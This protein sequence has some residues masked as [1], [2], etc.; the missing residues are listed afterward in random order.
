[1]TSTPRK[2]LA[3]LAETD[4]EFAEVRAFIGKV[5]YEGKKDLIACLGKINLLDS[6][7]CGIAESLLYKRTEFRH[8]AEVRLIYAG[9][10]GECTSDLYQIPVRPNELFDKFLFDPRMDTMA[11][12]TGRETFRKLGFKNAIERSGLYRAPEGLVFKL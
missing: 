10:D 3:A 1:M 4:P 11:F 6:S 12:K 7:G 8:E 5:S 9:P 2:L